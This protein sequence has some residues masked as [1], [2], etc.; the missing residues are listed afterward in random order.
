MKRFSLKMHIGNGIKAS[1]SEVVHFFNLDPKSNL[2]LRSMEF[3]YPLKSP[4]SF[5]LVKK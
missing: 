3:C 4:S 1:K 5:D 2:G